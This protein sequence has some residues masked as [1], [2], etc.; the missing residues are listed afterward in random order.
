MLRL[1]MM[2]RGAVNLWWIYMRLVA[3]DVDESRFAELRD[4]AA[5]ETRPTTRFVTGPRMVYEYLLLGVPEEEP[6]P[7][8][9]PPPLL[10]L[11]LLPPMPLLLLLVGAGGAEGGAS[12]ASPTSTATAC[13]AKEVET[14]AASS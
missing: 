11:L 4:G 13:W 10:L 12:T 5:E 9:P 1:F 3:V 7:P 8:P 2:M 6:P 14:P